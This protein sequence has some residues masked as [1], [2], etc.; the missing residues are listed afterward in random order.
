MGVETVVVS[1]LLLGSPG[2]KSH[3]DVNAAKKCRQYYIG[4]G[5]GFP[6][7]RA[8]MSLVSLELPLAYPS[9]KGAPKSD[10][11]SNKKL[12][13]VTLPSPILEL[14]HTPLPLLVLR[15]GSVPQVPHNFIV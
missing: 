15:A 7:V 14:Q 11:G 8:V 2:T 12:K 13:L 1:R 3:S 9:T 5:G 10:A 4:E 6:Q